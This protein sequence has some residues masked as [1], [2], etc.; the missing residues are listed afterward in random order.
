MFPQVPEL[1]PCVSICLQ[2]F[3]FWLPKW[4]VEA[5]YQTSFLSFFLHKCTFWAQFFFTWKYVNWGKISKNFPIFFLSKFPRF[6]QN[7]STWQYFLYTYN[8]WYLWQI[9]ALRDITNCFIRCN[10]AWGRWPSWRRNCKF[11]N[12]VLPGSSFSTGMSGFVEINSS[13]SWTATLSSGEAAP[14]DPRPCSSSPTVEQSLRS[15]RCVC[16]FTC[17]S[18]FDHESTVIYVLLFVRL[19]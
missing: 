2:T 10:F 18:L 19:P 12:M 15:G 6:S 11:T 3:D 5:W 14:L 1:W 17:F 4:H 13:F 8:L 7:F 9:W 16:L